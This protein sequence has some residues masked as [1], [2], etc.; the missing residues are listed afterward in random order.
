MQGPGKVP[1]DPQEASIRSQKKHDG[2]DH[3]AE[4]D[5]IHLVLIPLQV[6]P[7]SLLQLTHRRAKLVKEDIALED[8]R[9]GT[10]TGEMAS[11]HLSDLGESKI[12]IPLV[13][14]FFHRRQADSRKPKGTRL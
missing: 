12:A 3:Q 4:I 9:L 11:L 6:L 2:S 7:N 10:R 5:G 13:G 8:A 14:H 1:Q